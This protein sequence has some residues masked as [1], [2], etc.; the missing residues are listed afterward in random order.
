MGEE[1][2]FI[3]RV[4]ECIAEIVVAGMAVAKDSHSCQPPLFCLSW[5][6]LPPMIEDGGGLVFLYWVISEM[7]LLAFLSYSTTDWTDCTARESS[8]H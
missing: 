4:E 6:F 7:M 5:E 2:E 1:V 3:K 8:F